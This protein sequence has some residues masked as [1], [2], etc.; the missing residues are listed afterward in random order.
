MEHHRPSLAFE[1][2]S[3]EHPRDLTHVRDAM[4]RYLARDT[5]MSKLQSHEYFATYFGTEEE[6]HKLEAW[7][8]CLR[9]VFEKVQC[10]LAIHIYALFDIIVT[11]EQF[12]ESVTKILKEL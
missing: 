11:S 2:S 5:D 12:R 4:M 10:R 7:E 3:A 6:E 8:G 9:H 1:H